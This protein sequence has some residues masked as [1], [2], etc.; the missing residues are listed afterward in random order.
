MTNKRKRNESGCCIICVGS[1]GSG[2]VQ[3]RHRIVSKLVY[4]N[5]YTLHITI[6]VT[7]NM[8]Y[9]CLV[10]SWSVCVCDKVLLIIFTINTWHMLPSHCHY[11]AWQHDIIYWLPQSSTIS[12]MT[13]QHIATSDSVA[14]VTTECQLYT[15]LM[16]TEAASWLDTV[17]WEDKKKQDM[18]SFR[19]NAMIPVLCR[20]LLLNPKVYF[21]PVAL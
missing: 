19:N 10:F 21:F 20:S 6:H 12:I 14:S 2:K 1:T 11:Q 18:E 15:N 3:Y 5:I 7:T 17:G 16:D 8:Q 4:F 13:G 9:W